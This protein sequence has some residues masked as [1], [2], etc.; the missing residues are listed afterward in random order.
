[1]HR[2]SIAKNQVRACAST[3]KV[4]SIIARRKERYTRRMLSKD[5]VSHLAL[6]NH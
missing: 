4:M 2:C 5:R 3:K 1:M 6:D